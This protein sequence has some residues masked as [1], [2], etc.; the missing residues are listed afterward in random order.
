MV[1]LD[2]VLRALRAGDRRHDRRQVEL[3]VFGVLRLHIL[4][5]VDVVPQLVRLRI[6]LDERHLLVGTAGQAQVVERDVIDREDA[7]R[8]AELRAHVAD[9]R[10]VGERYGRDAFAVELDELA[11]DAVLAQHVGD[12]EHHVGRRDAFGDRPLELEADDARHEHRDRLAEHGGLGFD[13]A[14]APAEHT[15]SVDGRGVRV[16]ADARIEVRER[17]A[18][19]GGLAHDDLGEVFDV[20]LVDDAGPRRHH[21]EVLEGLLAPAQELVAF[22]V[23]FVFDVHVDLH[24]VIHTVGVD[25]HGM[26]DDHVGLHLR[27]DHLGV[28]AELLDGVAHRGQVDDARHAGEVLHDDAR[29]RELDLMAW[30]GCRVPIEQR[31]HVLVGDVGAVLVAHKVLDEHL[32]RI[33]KVV[34]ALKVGDAVVVVRLLPDVEDVQLVVAHGHGF[35]PNVLWNW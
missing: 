12:G 34:N 7:A 6:R 28:A 8:R 21:A 22:A 18:V 31:L 5:V 16:G 23:A 33:R 11:D 9:R 10:A 13:A 15:E 1:E 19:G 3:E 20:D 26:V 25:L 2:A 14:D 29:R 17:P 27:V 4:R 32:E 24:G 30:I 35:P